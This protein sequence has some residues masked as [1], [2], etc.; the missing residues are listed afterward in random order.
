MAKLTQQE[1]MERMTRA[2]QDVAVNAA[3]HARMDEVRMTK[4]T[5]QVAAMMFSLMAH[6]FATPE[7]DALMNMAATLRGGAI[8]S[9]T[10]G[11]V[12]EFA[13]AARNK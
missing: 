9:S 12:Q 4:G 10:Y 7:L 11:K 2:A 8:A 13:K 3:A 6:G 1:Q 5:A